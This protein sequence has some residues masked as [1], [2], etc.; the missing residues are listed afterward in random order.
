MASRRQSPARSRLDRPFAC[1]SSK[2]IGGENIRFL[3]PCTVSQLLIP[4]STNLAKAPHARSFE[5]GRSRLI[6]K[7]RR[8]A[9]IPSGN[10]SARS[11]AREQIALNEDAG[12]NV[13]TSAEERRRPFLAG[14]QPSRIIHANRCFLGQAFRWEKRALPC[15]LPYKLT[16]KVIAVSHPRCY[17]ES[18]SS[19]LASRR[20]PR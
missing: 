10:R 20:P 1:N 16:A 13:F 5:P 17:A 6:A 19:D 9:Q 11:V 4:G 18:S 8:F 15:L 3:L 12:A 2:H 7:D 14:L